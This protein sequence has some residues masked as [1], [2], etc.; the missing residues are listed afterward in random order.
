M[1]EIL[2]GSS[3]TNERGRV[4]MALTEMLTLFH[5]PN[6]A[7]PKAELKRNNNAVT[8]DCALSS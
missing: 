6:K 3:S 7:A 4:E 1:R 8:K 2:S 5:V